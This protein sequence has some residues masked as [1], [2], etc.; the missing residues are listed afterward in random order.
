MSKIDKTAL[1]QY[2]LEQAREVLKDGRALFDMER[3]PLS[4]VNRAYYSMFYAVLALLVAINKDAAKHQ[5]ALAFFDEYFIKTKIFPKEM[6]KWIHAAFESRQA[7]DYRDM[8]VVSREEAQEILESAESF[9][10]A[11]EE[12][13]AAR[14]KAER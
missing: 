11:A 1:I 7:G 9:L 4:V 12:W 14:R 10:Q 6:S 8:L 2:R 13:L 5:G 3:T